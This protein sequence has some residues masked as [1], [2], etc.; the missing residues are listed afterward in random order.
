MKRL[1][2]LGLITSVLHASPLDELRENSYGFVRFEVGITEW[3]LEQFGAV[4]IQTERVYHQFGELDTTEESIASF[5]EEIGFNEKK[6]AHQTASRL[7]QI[8]QQVIATSGKETAWIC[9]RSFI[10]TPRYDVPRWHVDGPYYHSD[11]AEDLLFKFVVTLKGP[12]TLFYPLTLN[13]RKAT[14]KTIHN[15]HYMMNFCRNEKIL[16]PKLGEG[17]IFRGGQYTAKTALHSE[18]PIHETRLFFSM[19]PCIEEQLPFLKARVIA[20]YPKDSRN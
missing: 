18:P 5:I 7:K 17:V 8:A 10:P 1:L 6:L 16:S 2:F 20:L 13:E 12:T 14:E 9:L 19:V 4:D 15:R 3:D 11:S